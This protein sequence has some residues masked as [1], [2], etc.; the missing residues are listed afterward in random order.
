MRRGK[1]AARMAGPAPVYPVELPRLRRIVVVIDFDLGRPM[2]RVWQL[3]KSKRIDCYRVRAPD[4]KVW[5]GRWG[6]ARV[7][8]EIRHAYIRVSKS[9]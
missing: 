1:E 4:G 9:A 3:W 5:P 8:A 7:L 2:I 6:W